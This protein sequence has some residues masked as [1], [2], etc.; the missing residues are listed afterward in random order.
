MMSMAKPTD[1]PANTNKL[2]T[3]YQS[4]VKFCEEIAGKESDTVHKKF[5]ILSMLDPETRRATVQFQAQ[6]EK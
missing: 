1:S 5:V 2:L 3:E 6:D 4:K